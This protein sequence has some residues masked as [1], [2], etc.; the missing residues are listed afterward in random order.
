M[1]PESGGAGLFLV[2]SWGRI[3]DTPLRRSLLLES[4][5]H[6]KWPRWMVAMVLTV[7]LTAMSTRRSRHHDYSV[8]DHPLVSGGKSARA[9]LAREWGTDKGIPTGR[10]GQ[11]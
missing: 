3:N 9:P 11:A 6:C 2:W 10:K 8:K 5:K 1:D 7:D 4:I